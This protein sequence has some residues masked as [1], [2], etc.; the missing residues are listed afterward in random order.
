MDPIA[1]LVDEGDHG[2]GGKFLGGSGAPVTI[3]VITESG[4]SHVHLPPLGALL[5]WRNLPYITVYQ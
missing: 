5:C 3:L 4:H 1:H 2:G